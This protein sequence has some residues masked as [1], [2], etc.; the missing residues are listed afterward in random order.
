MVNLLEDPG[1]EGGGAAWAA[2]GSVLFA[3]DWAR[4]GGVGALLSGSLVGFPDTHPVAAKIAQVVTVEA[5]RV[6]TF[7]AW[8]KAGTGS[9]SLRLFVEDTPVAEIDIASAADW[10]LVQH[11]FTP[12]ASGPITVSIEAGAVS[13]WQVDDASLVALEAVIMARSLR[14][15]WLAFANRL[16]SV[17]KADGYYHDVARVLPSAAP[18]A[19]SGKEP[20]L[21]CL[22]VEHS[23]PFGSMDMGVFEVPLRQSV[24]IYPERNSST[25]LEGSTSDDVLKWVEDVIK[26]M[27]E[28]DELAPWDLASGRTIETVRYIDW[29]AGVSPDGTMAYLRVQFEALCKFTRAEL[30]PNGA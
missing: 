24:Y 2:S 14:L 21:V 12:D 18:P 3:P 23:G 22:P 8:V 6:Y 25:N 13:H 17:R 16:M 10:T 28:S 11:A 9:A 1:F 19:V 30:G 7:E 29:E 26:V 15:A 4:S 5:S 20:P 27:S